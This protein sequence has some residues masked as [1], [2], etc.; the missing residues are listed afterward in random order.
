[1]NSN[2]HTVNEHFENRAPEV[3]ANYAAILKAAKKLGGKAQLRFCTSGN[4]SFQ[5]SRTSGKF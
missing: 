2:H 4:A 5:N 3:R 1:M